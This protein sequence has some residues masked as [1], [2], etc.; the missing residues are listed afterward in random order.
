MGD[1][2][3]SNHLKISLDG[4]N[5]IDYT[6]YGGVGLEYSWR[7]MAF[8]RGGTHLFHDTAGLSLG[9]GLKWGMIVVDYAYVNYGILKETHQFG[10]SL[11]F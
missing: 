2:E 7:D 10:I 6:V 11:V 5:P 3:S 4:I 9:G 8:V 1:E